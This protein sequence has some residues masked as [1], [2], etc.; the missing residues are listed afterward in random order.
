MADRIVARRYAEAFVRTA[1]ASQRLEENLRDLKAIAG[2][3]AQSKALRDFLGSPEIGPED[4][5]RL[6]HRVWAD[7]AREETLAL[8][9]LL[10]KK[11]RMNHLPL[12]AD[13]AVKVAEQRQGILRGEATTAH[14]I[15]SA[16]TERL[17]GAVGQVL[18]KKVLLERRVD[19]EIL[20]GVQIKVGSTLLDGSVRKL[21]EE[22]RGQLKSV[23]VN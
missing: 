3:Y 15:S 4:K 20:G 5:V 9:K 18:G 12:L 23:K 6:T 22:V 7:S 11:D 8:L 13:E 10:L 21:L 17:A 19:P 2:T 16:E 1:E 14:P